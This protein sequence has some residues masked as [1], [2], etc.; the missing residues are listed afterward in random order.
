MN[1]AG[2]SRRFPVAVVTG[3]RA[4]FGLLEGVIAHLFRSPSVEPTVLVAGMHLVAELGETAREVER[5]FP[6][7]ARIPMSPPEDSPGGMALALA[8]GIGSFAAV[9]GEIRPGLLLVLGD[10]LEPLAAALAASYL[11]IPIAHL[12]GGD[13]SGHLLDDLHRDLIS[14]LACIHFPA[15]FRSAERLRALGVAG[16]VQV[17]GAPGLDAILAVPARPREEVLQALG[18]PPAAR[19]LVTLFH[20]VP[21]EAGPGGSR[22]A[23]E[24]EEVLAAAAEYARREGAWSVIL[25]PNNDAGHRAVIGAIEKRRD[26][27]RTLIFPSLTRDLFTG[28]L[29]CAEA[30]L[31]NSSSGIIESVSLGLAVVN[32][33]ARQAGRER[34]PNV[35]DAPAERGALLEALARA[36]SDPLVLA[37]LASRRNLYGDGRAADR[38]ARALENYAEATPA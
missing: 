11:R 13:V 3:S 37:A 16:E 4:E 26:D 7:A 30:L 14:R 2:R 25:Y 19:V 28:L 23:A 5:R 36:R 27:P 18:I 9:L 10:R 24:A 8:G 32:V 15:T 33:G 29:S 12:H 21:A 6:V 22:A 17:V 35:I 20:P 1:G 34:N 31:G 38:I